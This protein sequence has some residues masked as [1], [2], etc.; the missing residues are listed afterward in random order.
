MRVLGRSTI[1][2]LG[3]R[4][5]GNRVIPRRLSGLSWG[6]V[7]SDGDEPVRYCAE[8]YDGPRGD[9]LW[10]GRGARGFIALGG[11]ERTRK[12]REN[13][14]M[15]GGPR[16]PRKRGPE[17][18]AHLKTPATRMRGWYIMVPPLALCDAV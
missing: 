8:S 18:A 15:T 14:A 5:L 6:F 12:A 16:V 13:S 4:E 1:I 3:S 9:R 2:S 10:R 17:V 7:E 11:V